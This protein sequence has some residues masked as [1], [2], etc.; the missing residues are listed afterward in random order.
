ME[1]EYWMDLMKQSDSYLNPSTLLE[2]KLLSIEK[3]LNR[4]ISSA[5]KKP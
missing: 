2:D 1:T 5:K 3:L 4:I